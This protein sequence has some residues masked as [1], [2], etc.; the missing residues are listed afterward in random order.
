MAGVEGNA[1]NPN[2][3]PDIKQIGMNSRFGAE[4][5]ADPREAAKKRKISWRSVRRATQRIAGLEFT[6]ESKPTAATITRMMGKPGTITGAQIAAI[7]L[8]ELVSKGNLKAIK[9]FTEQ[10]DGKLVQK[11]IQ[12][13]ATLAEIVSKSYDPQFLS[14]KDDEPDEESST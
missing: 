13:S 9:E 8:F 6:E 3:H 14:G 10:V 4:G 12:A 11:S 2:G 5:G 1:G 7:R